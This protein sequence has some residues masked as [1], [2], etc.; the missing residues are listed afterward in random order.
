MICQWL[1]VPFARNKLLKLV[2]VRFS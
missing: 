1:T 2:L